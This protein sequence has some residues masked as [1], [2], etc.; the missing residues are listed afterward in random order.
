[1]RNFHPSGVRRPSRRGGLLTGALWAAAA[2]TAL[3]GVT[4]CSDDG[5]G[6]QSKPPE[7]SSTPAGHVCGGA[8]D[9]SAAAA[10]K[11]LSGTDG[12]RELSGSHFSLGNAAAQLSGSAQHDEC[13]VY[14]PGDSSGAPLLR[15]DFKAAD[16]H[17]TRSEVEKLSSGKDLTFYDLG[18]YAATSDENSTA[19]Y[20]ACTTKGSGGRQS[21][22]VDA[23]MYTT[24]GQLKGDS[25]S[26]DRM[27]VLNSFARRLADQ[28]GCADEAHLPSAV[29]EGESAQQ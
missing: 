16:D 26:K 14:L 2:A 4:A 6:N 28:L 24:A 20:F 23:S 22:Y 13:N 18:A 5:S 10:L 12:F 19:L 7:A 21:R 1:M 8:F 27:T 15:L 17:P 9:G 11:R 25:T 3:A 29:P